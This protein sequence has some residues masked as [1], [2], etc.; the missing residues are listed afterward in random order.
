MMNLALI[1]RFIKDDSIISPQLSYLI[2][3]F[4]SVI[5]GN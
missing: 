3:P 2:Q 5:R 1:P 4:L